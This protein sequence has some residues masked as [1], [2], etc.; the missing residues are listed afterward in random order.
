M[1]VNVAGR[2]VRLKLTSMDVTSLLNL[3]RE[4]GLRESGEAR[5]RER[6][7]DR[8][9]E[10]ERRG[11]ERERR[12][13]RKR[14]LQLLLAQTEATET[15]GRRETRRSCRGTLLQRRMPDAGRMEILHQPDIAGFHQSVQSALQELH[16]LLLLIKHSHSLP[17][18]SHVLPLL[19]TTKQMQLGGKRP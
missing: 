16:Q 13:S 4:A 9:R 15:L 1:Y 12:K 8:E 10:R 2:T 18:P 7:G 11:R 19:A 3:E 17:P 5:G 14:R 6:E